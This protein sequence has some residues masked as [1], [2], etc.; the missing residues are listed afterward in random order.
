MAETNTHKR[1]GLR[2]LLWLVAGLVGL[3]VLA[4]I[5]V[6]V[7]VQSDAVGSYVRNR[8]VPQ[9][10]E[11][12]GR[13]VTIGDVDVSLLP[14]PSARISDVRVAGD[15][16]DRPLVAAPEAVGHIDLW[17]LLRSF[18]KEI[19]LS[20]L[21]LRQPEVN[22]VRRAD[23]TW[24]YQ[25]ILDHLKQTGGQEQP[26]GAK[27]EVVIERAA[28]ND[29]LLR[30]VDLS[31]PGGAATAEVKHFDLEG[32]NIGIGEPLAVKLRAAVQAEK[33]NLE[34]NFTVDPLPASVANLGPGQWPNVRGQ[35][36]LRDAPIG[37]LRNL[38]PPGF[39]ETVTGGTIRLQS[40]L[41]TEAGRYVARGT[42]RAGGLQMRG[43]PAD[44]SFAF[45]ASVDPA[46]R[47]DLRLDLSNIALK[48]P[49]VDLGGTAS[50]Q[51]TERFQFAL[52][53]PL[54]DMNALM[55][56]LPQKEKAEA[57]AEKGPSLLSPAA[58]S[59]VAGLVGN[60]T[61]KVDRLVN[62]KLTANDVVA[63]ATLRGGKLTLDQ[64]KAG[65]YGGS[66][67]A[68][69]T[70]VDL[71]EAIPSWSLKAN[72]AGVQLAEAMQQITGRSPLSGQLGSQVNLEGAGVNWQAIRDA[73]TGSG[74]V[75]LQQGSL[76]GANLDQSIAQSIGAGLQRLGYGNTGT[77]VA[78]T[79]TA[80]EDLRAQFVVKNGWMALR[81][82]IRTKT[83]FGVLELNGRIGLDHQLDLVGKAELSPA[84]VAQI[85]GNQ[86]KP[87]GPV[88]VPIEL[89]GTLEKPAVGGISTE[90]VAQAILPRG[91]VEKQVQQEAERQKEKAQR[92]AA[93]RIG[94]IL[95]GG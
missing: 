63:Q 8:A 60:G 43:H 92:E 93:R 17:T 23:G 70:S 1:S 24:D 15:E 4:V 39:A 2:L 72:L 11:R 56:A 28:L 78:K 48:G 79:G 77:V 86:F 49:G 22:L 52:A 9:L 46:N 44:G 94:D 66:V 47:K 19:Q 75:E 45:T 6:A 53:G 33:Q 82:P 14:A 67:D 54:L 34:A 12:I 68:S 13:P 71:A 87:S 62:G 7:L 26:G 50:L 73:I 16:P 90:A 35:M 37:S 59:K 69:G 25:S 91:K 51:G 95:R 27:R 20:S 32:K 81:Q 3:L 89:G 58:R 61:L 5:L 65:F 85:T 41:A 83:P 55:G 10:A 31:A 29:G 42:A 88:E 18:G 80:L 84:F 21:E 36:E 40:D 74:A 57:P 30:V 76:A 38:L 64:A